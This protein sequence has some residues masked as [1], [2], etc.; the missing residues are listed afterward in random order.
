[1]AG[2]ATL[3]GDTTVSTGS[4]D[5]TFTGTVNGGQALT[6]N[7]IGT[8]TFSAAVG[9]TTA[10]ASLRTDEGGTT[11]L[12]GNVTTT[13]DQTY[14]DAVTAGAITFTTTGG[15]SISAA[16]AANDFTGT[17]TLSTARP[18]GTTTGNVT[19]TDA[20]SLTLTGN[21]GGDLTATAGADGN[22]TFAGVVVVSGNL[23]ATAGLQINQTN[24]DSIA[25]SR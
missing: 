6:V 22:L 21:V 25:E 3:G 13:G 17:V 9:N 15:G 4:G 24:T 5:A 2:T 12:G 1:V 16:N 23:T 10:L 18:A 11:V 14:T 19:L 20:N 7:S 8:T